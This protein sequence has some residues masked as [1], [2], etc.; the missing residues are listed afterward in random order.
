MASN[1]DGEGDN[2][3]FH[4]RQALILD[5]DNPAAANNDVFG[6]SIRLSCSGCITPHNTQARLHALTRSMTLLKFHA[7]NMQPKQQKLNYV[8]KMY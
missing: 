6:Q 1:R 5:S 3:V 8:C 4:L 2:D 7:Q